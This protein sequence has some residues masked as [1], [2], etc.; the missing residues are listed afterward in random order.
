MQAAGAPSD[1]EGIGAYDLERCRQGD[2]SALERVFRAES[3]ALER[4]IG[5]LIGPTADVEDLLQNTLIAAID[6]FPRFRGEAS[7]RTWLARIAVHVAGDHLRRPEARRP[8]VALEL[9]AAE[10]RAPGPD[11]EAALDERRALERLYI[12]LDAISAAQRIAFVL[13]VV[14][15]R[16]IGEVAALMGAT[17]AGT[18]SRVFF[19][20]RALM[21]RISRDPALRDLGT[22]W[23]T[24]KERS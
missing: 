14:D 6:A 15:G 23:L 19:G 10:P 24:R 17:E 22:G 12:H 20:R 9:L 8:R 21:A 7:V 3:P 1:P 18:K 5:R 2:R 16:S 11:P 13:H 4:L